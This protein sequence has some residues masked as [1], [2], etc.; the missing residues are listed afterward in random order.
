MNLEWKGLIALVDNFRKKLLVNY[1][2]M[3][4]REPSILNEVVEQFSYDI[5]NIINDSNE[6]KSIV[7]LKKQ[8][9]EIL[10]INENNKETEVIL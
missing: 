8:I 6:S 7:Q 4:K 1:L 2:E 10:K 5:S 3:V 9:M